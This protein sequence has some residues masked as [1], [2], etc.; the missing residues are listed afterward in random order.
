M[1]VSHAITLESSNGRS[2]LIAEIC[3][4]DGE[5]DEV[6]L[7]L[8]ATVGVVRG[9]AG[10]NAGPKERGD[11]IPLKGARLTQPLAGHPELWA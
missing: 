1:T 11:A 4:T 6:G 9:L 8:R 2:V 3:S 7:D 10:G 5:G